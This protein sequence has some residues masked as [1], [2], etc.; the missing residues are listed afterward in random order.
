MKP[1]PARR[2]AGEG[3]LVAAVSHELRQP[4]ASIRGFTEMMLAHWADFPEQD[5]LQMLE[6]ILHES[7]RVGRMV[8]ELLEGSRLDAGQLKLRLRATD[9]GEV[10]NSAVRNLEAVFPAMRATVEVPEDLPLVM[11][12]RYKLEQVV[13]NILENACKYGDPASITVTARRRPAPGHTR[14]GAQGRSQPT[15]QV[16]P[17]A[18]QAGHPMAQ[19]APS[20]GQD[21]QVEVTVVDAGPGIDA[22]VLPRVTEKFVRSGRSP[23]GGLGLGLWISKGIIEAH[24]GQLVAR[25]LP[26]RGTSV[27]FTIPLRPDGKAGKLA[28]S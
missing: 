27:S 28:G 15:G 14:R 8:D 13:G 22:D 24:G 25:S 20:V 11:A 19:A 23:G 2:R 21:G 1:A 9:V 16:G 12:D 18:G 6:Q 26:G 10:V 17:R 5:K 7:K 3:E 4:L